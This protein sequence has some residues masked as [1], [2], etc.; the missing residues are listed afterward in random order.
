MLLIKS[1]LREVEAREKLQT[2]TAELR[3]SSV[4]IG[5]ATFDP[6]ALDGTNPKSPQELVEEAD[7]D[8]FLDKK[9]RKS[10]R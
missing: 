6:N 8:L 4:S 7:K 2:L 1:V 9:S 10:E 5:V 3:E